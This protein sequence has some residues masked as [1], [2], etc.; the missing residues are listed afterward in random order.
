MVQVPFYDMR[1]WPQGV[2]LV[3]R[4]ARK[5][6]SI[7][8]IGRGTLIVLDSEYPHRTAWVSGRLM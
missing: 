3:S 4:L 5:G 7:Y 1:C 6:Q 2:A 8:Y